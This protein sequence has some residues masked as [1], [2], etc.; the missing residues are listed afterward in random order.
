MGIF[1]NVQ[2][3]DYTEKLAYRGAAVETGKILPMREKP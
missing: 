1:Y 3:G 2:V